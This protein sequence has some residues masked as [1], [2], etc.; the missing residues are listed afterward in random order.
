[1]PIDI[2]ILLN[3]VLGLI[4]FGLGLSLTKEDFKHLF[5]QPRALSIGLASQMLLLPF[6]AWIIAK[7]SGLGAEMQVGIMILSVC[8]GGITSNLVSYYV[9][10]NVALAISLTVCN[11]LLS[12]FTIPFLVNLFLQ[13]FMHSGKMIELPFWKTMFDIFIVTVMPAMLGMLTRHQFGKH[14]VKT[15]KYLNIILPLLLLMVFAFKFTA[16]SEKGGTAMS[17][18]D[19]RDLSAWMIALNIASMIAGYLVGI[20]GRLS[21][22]NRITIAVE[23]GLHNTAL[24][25]LIA[26]DK[27]GIPAMEKPAL[28][29]A[30][31]SFVI[32]FLVA[33]ALMKLDPTVKKETNA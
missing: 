3:I 7:Q 19:L 30:L 22:K 17:G 8:P 6:L 4:M 26:G 5:D 32:T 31:Y 15:E 14:A 28:V 11:A 13:H 33:W 18:N 9:K 1:M 29:Y 25:L 2:N 20:L 21:F 12:L 24:A 16:G 27:L 10:G 23:V